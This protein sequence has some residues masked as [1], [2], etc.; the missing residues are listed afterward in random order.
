M[1]PNGSN[2]KT[3]IYLQAKP[4]VWFT[5]LSVSF[6]YPNLNGR[7]VQSDQIAI[8]SNGTKAIYLSSTFTVSCLAVW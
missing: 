2:T 5:L 6:L 7:R 4:A 8:R 3:E 1:V